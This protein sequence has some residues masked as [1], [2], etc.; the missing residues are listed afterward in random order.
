MIIK[1]VNLGKFTGQIWEM[2]KKLFALGVIT[3]YSFE[4]DIPKVLDD[5]A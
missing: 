5:T 1:E 2:F 4:R 3:I